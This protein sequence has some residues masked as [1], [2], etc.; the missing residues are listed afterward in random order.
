MTFS[1]ILATRLAVNLLIVGTLGCGVYIAD[2]SEPAA[3][4][5]TPG[6]S[7]CWDG[8]QVRTVS[9]ECP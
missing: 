8:M 7:E 3:Q 4:T 6:V 1:R 9:G 2:L 5:T